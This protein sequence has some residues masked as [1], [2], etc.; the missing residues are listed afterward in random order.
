LKWEFLSPLQSRLH[1]WTCPRWDTPHAHRPIRDFY[2]PHLAFQ[3]FQGPPSIQA[4]VPPGAAQ[5]PSR[6]APKIDVLSRAN[7]CRWDCLIKTA[8]DGYTWLSSPFAVTH[9][10]LFGFSGPALALFLHLN[11]CSSNSPHSTFGHSLQSPGS[12]FFAFPSRTPLFI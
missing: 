7:L 4:R 11:F 5:S 2:T 6:R 8:P 12:V 3:L 1:S 10:F 9:F